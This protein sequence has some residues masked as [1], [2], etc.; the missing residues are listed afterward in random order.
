LDVDKK[1]KGKYRLMPDLRVTNK[2]MKTTG[3]LQPGLSSL[4][5]IPVGFEL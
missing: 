4:A 2:A 1:A 5:M 3:V